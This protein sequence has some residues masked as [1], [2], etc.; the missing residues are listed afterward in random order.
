MSRC[1]PLVLAEGVG[2]QRPTPIASSLRASS[3]RLEQGGRVE[4]LIRGIYIRASCS[5]PQ[6]GFDCFRLAPP[7][8]S[9]NP[10]TPASADG[11]RSLS[12]AP[13]PVPSVATA[14]SADA[15][16]SHVPAAP[17]RPLAR[18]RWSAYADDSGRSAFPLGPPSFAPEGPPAKRA[19]ISLE[20]LA[21]PL[22]S[23]RPSQA[24]SWARRPA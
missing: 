16:V 9:A 24:F 10:T 8:G 21:V 13:P 5:T 14:P 17:A 15:V 3:P 18:R 7:D 19:S 2:F 4:T 6:S 11:D 1:R 20:S 23:N 22:R 12:V